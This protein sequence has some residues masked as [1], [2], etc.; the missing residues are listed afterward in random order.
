MGCGWDKDAAL[1]R[2]PIGRPGLII[3]F[4]HS[5]AVTLFAD[6]LHRGQIAIEIR[7]E[8]SVETGELRD[9]L[10]PLVAVVADELAD[11]APVLLLDV[12]LVVLMGRPAARDGEVFLRAVA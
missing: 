6:E 12:G 4:A 3:V 10:R 9:R 1:L 7:M 5:R 2:A 11:H 8:E